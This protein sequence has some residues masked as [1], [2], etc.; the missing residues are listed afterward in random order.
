MAQNVADARH[1][2]PGNFWMTGFQ[3]IRKVAARLGNNLDAT[4][5]QPLPLPI[6]L[7]SIERNIQQYGID[8]FDGLDDVGQAGDERTRNH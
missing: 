5:D 7:K 6:G 3:F 8:T 4:L 1:F 2:Y